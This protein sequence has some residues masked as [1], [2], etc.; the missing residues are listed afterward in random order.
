MIA[1]SS[2]DG[3]RPTGA[4]FLT[5][6]ASAWL[7]GSCGSETEVVDCYRDPGQLGCA[8]ARGGGQGSMVVRLGLVAPLTGSASGA[9]SNILNA[10]SLALEEAGGGVGDYTVELVPIDSESASD[11]ARTAELY[12]AAI[13]SNDLIAG[14]L[15]WHSGVAV[16]LM[17]VAADAE[18][19]HLFGLGATDAI[20]QKYASDPERYRVWSAKGWPQPSTYVRSYLD[21]LECLLSSA[22]TEATAATPWSPGQRSMYVVVEPGSWG[23]AF[24]AGVTDNVTAPGGFWAGQGWTVAGSIELSADDDATELNRKA[25]QVADSGASVVLMTTTAESFGQF[26]QA[27][28]QAADPDPLIVAEGLGWTQQSLDSAGLAAVGVLD[29]GYAPYNGDPDRAATVT[30]FREAFERRF[31]TP[32]NTSSAGLAYDYTRFALRVLERALEKSGTLTRA[33]VLDVYA[34]EVRTGQL[35][36]E[37]GVVMSSYAYTSTSA[38]DP[39]YGLGEY[40]F[41]VYQYQGPNGEG[42]IETTTV[43]PGTLKN[44][45]VVIPR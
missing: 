33:S 15:N 45:D 30:Q 10:A 2:T 12:R 23:G 36:F 29:G 13:T 31:G 16:E 19:A 25:A 39:S 3:R 34:N 38:P 35:R 37:Q 8:P 32:P 14:L 41:P 17:D 40:Y 28:R 18:M 7:A 11:P 24:A 5:L 44:A 6:L 43:F 9:G 4:T 26:V 27:L 20:N 22:C 1:R 21:L 42:A